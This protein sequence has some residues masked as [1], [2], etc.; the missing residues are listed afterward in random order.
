MSPGVIG[1]NNDST[2]SEKIYARVTNNDNTT[3]DITVDLTVI[4][5]EG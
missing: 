1:W 5:M 3:R 4:K 2:P